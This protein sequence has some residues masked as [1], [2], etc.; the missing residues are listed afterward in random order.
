MAPSL[1]LDCE[2]LCE[3]DKGQEYGHGFPACGHGDC[4][5]SVEFSNQ[6]QDDVDAEIPGYGKQRGVSISFYWMLKYGKLFQRRRNK[7]TYPGEKDHS[8]E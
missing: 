2:R 4:Q 7:L 8:V 5:Q 1:V 3:R 6:G